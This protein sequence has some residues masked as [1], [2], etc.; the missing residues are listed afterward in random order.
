MSRSHHRDSRR[1]QPRKFDVYRLTT[2]Y[3]I[4]TTGAAGVTTKDVM[5][6]FATDYGAK[7]YQATLS[8]PRFDVTSEGTGTGTGSNSFTVGFMVGSNQLDAADLDPVAN[9]NE[10][11]WDRKWY[12]Q[13]NSNPVGVPWAM[14][15]A[16]QS[17]LEVRTRRTL[18][19]LDD[20]LWT[21]VRA[22][23][24]GF[25]ALTVTVSLVVGILYA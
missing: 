15:G 10:F 11:W 24:A 12:L 8:I 14:Q 6:Q 19:N 20:T 9:P 13:N 23:F 16:A 18:K 25:T 22:D 3:N 4:S 2:S 1:P 7:P 21:A 5:G 17:N